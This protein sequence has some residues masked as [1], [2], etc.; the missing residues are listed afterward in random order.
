MPPDEL[1]GLLGGIQNRVELLGWIDDPEDFYKRIRLLIHPAK[2]EAYG[3]VVAEAMAR[4]IPVLTSEATGAAAEV[5]P[6]G[7][8]LPHTAPVAQ[9]IQSTRDLLAT[10]PIEFPPPRLWPEVAADY[11][12][13]YTEIQ[14]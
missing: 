9:W 12:S 1:S 10:P 6:A 14:K 8:M 2:L 4:R 13:L 7:R 3:M 11:E 5:G